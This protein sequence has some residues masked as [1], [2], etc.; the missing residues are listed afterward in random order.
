M[1]YGSCKSKKMV[2]CCRLRSKSNVKGWQP[3]SC[4]S[5]TTALHP[6]LMSSLSEQKPSGTFSPSVVFF[7]R[8]LQRLTHASLRRLCRAWHLSCAVS[9]SGFTIRL[10]RPGY[11]FL[12][13]PQCPR[14]KNPLTPV[15]S[16]WW[17]SVALLSDLTY[18]QVMTYYLHI[19]IKI[20]NVSARLIS[21]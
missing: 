13:R 12:S 20:G 7:T 16:L 2:Y 9:I 10:C 14:R 18:M 5:F 15:F 11:D 3:F 8:C 19:C 21:K 1:V 17:S 6:D 4:S